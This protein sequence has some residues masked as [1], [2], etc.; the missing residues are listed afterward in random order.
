[1]TWV[2]NLF[3]L[4][5]VSAFT[6]EFPHV[7]RQPGYICTMEECRGWENVNSRDGGRMPIRSFSTGLWPQERQHLGTEAF[8][9]LK[10]WVQGRNLHRR[11]R[12]KREGGH[13]WDREQN[14]FRKCTASFPN[15]LTLRTPMGP[16]AFAVS[17]YKSWW[18]NLLVAGWVG[19]WHSSTP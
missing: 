13:R 6:A 1:M 15:A 5:A 10:G 11:E 14:K 2:A 19:A 9:M 3:T 17:L 16:V 18:W 12:E 8:R 7:L 4:T